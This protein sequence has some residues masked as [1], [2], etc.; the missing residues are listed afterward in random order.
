MTRNHTP[1]DCSVK[2]GDL[3]GRKAVPAAEPKL[4]WPLAGQGDFLS[5]H[6]CR[7]YQ[8]SR[9][10]RRRKQRARNAAASVHAL[11]TGETSAVRGTQ[12]WRSAA[13]SKTAV[14]AIAQT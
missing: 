5:D 2:P 13:S 9:N 3:A 7:D 12:Q 8:N 6:Q 1:I 14:C 11:A 10:N 4:S